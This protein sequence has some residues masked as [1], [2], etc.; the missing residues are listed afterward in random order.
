M[1]NLASDNFKKQ[2]Q[3]Q[4][5]TQESNFAISGMS[6]AACA[7]RIE[8]VLNKKAGVASATVNFAAETA[9]VRHDDSVSD[10]QIRAWIAKAGF[11][12][13][14]LSEKSVVAEHDEH[15]GLWRLVLLWLLS[16]PFWV[17]MLGMM[18]GSHA[19]MPPIWLQFVLA[20]I[21]QFGFGWVFYKGATASI[22]GGLANMDVLVALGTSAIWAYSTYV[23]QQGEAH[24]YFE[25]SVMVIAFVSLGKF[26]EMRTK[27]HSLNSLT[28]LL[29]LIPKHAKIKRDG[30][31]QEVSVDSVQAGDVLLGRTGDSVAVDGVV[32]FGSGML[33]EAHLTGESRVL[34]KSVGDVVLAGSVISDGSFEYQ[35]RATGQDTALADVVSA[36]NEA[37]GTK[38]NIARLADKVAAVFVPAVVAIALI[39]FAVNFW[40]LGAFDEALL[41]AVA[42]LVIACPCALGLAT[43]AAIMAGMGTAA[44]HG[45]RFKDAPSL[46]AAGHVDTMVF[47]KTGTLTHGKPQISAVHLFADDLAKSANLSNFNETLALTLTASLEQHASHPLAKAFTQAASEQNLA[48]FEVTDVQS[49]I[50]KGLSGVIEPFGL[51]KVGVPEFADLPDFDAYLGNE[52][53]AQPQWRFASL[54]ALSIN[55]KAVAVYALTDTIKPTSERVVSK[56]KEDGIEVVILSGD[57]QAVVDD[58]AGKLGISKALGRL[59]P[60]DKAEFISQL[61]ADGRQVAMTGDGV[62]DAP[63]MA[64]AA[65]SFAVGAGSDVAR[66]TASAELVGESITHAYY[67]QKIARL[68]LKNIKQNL[69]FAFIYNAIGIVV[70]AVGLLNPMIAAAA[71]AASSISVLSNALRLK[72]VR[73]QLD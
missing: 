52:A 6:C 4:E 16:V 56:L 66:H 29:D 69:F 60:R 19:L 53:F 63:A 18:A 58:V 24:V 28:L 50:G 65:A 71:M 12:A 3:L 40:W 41:R 9:K 47:D 26:L 13:K 59:S 23:W 21:V 1:T 55:G 7:A 44:R 20:S 49:V 73:L 42:V 68:T 5:H 37:Q 15:G 36:L 64:A 48:L 22:R 67:A 14:P 39:T 70:A 33:D 62:N 45:V 54:V 57:H 31:W 10:E 17:G 8:K 35:A 43:P 38:A 30:A 25:A 51:I 32:T 11:D 46:E 61:Q 72:R 34:T 2:T 27:K